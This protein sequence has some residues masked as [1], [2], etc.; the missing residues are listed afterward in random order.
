MNKK[1]LMILIPVAAILVA[2]I[3]VLTYM[4]VAVPSTDNLYLEQIQYAERL[5]KSCDVYSAI[6]YYAG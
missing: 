3:G 2:A 5:M 4:L 6:L 1:L